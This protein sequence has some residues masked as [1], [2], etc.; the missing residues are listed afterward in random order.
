MSIVL[1]LRSIT[2]RYG[3]IAAL[4]DIDLDVHGGTFV[5]LLGPSG[6]GKTTLLR[7]V[8]GI[9]IPD[10]GDV[11]LGQRRVTTDP[12]FARNL[13][14]VFQDYALFPHMSV[15]ENVAFGIRMRGNPQE[16]KRPDERV[17]E[18]LELVGLS[19]FATR[20]PAELSGGQ[21]QRVA[22][23]RALAPRPSLLLMDEPLSNLDAKVREEM[24]SELK[25]IQRKADVTTL[26]V[27][28]DQEEA[29]AL[30]DKVVVMTEGRIAQIG[31]P[32]EVYSAPRDRFVADFIGKANILEGGGNPG[33]RQFETHTGV[34]LQLAEGLPEATV[35]V[36]IRPEH[37]MLSPGLKPNNSFEAKILSITYVGAARY[38]TLD[39]CGTPILSLLVNSIGMHRVSVGQL[40]RIAIS[41]EAIRPLISEA[42]V[43][44][45]Q[46]LAESTDMS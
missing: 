9:Q 39:L 15:F 24:R 13:A 44:S 41:P 2:K 37:V 17:G 5:S 30:S 28:H 29:L 35:A 27:T 10:S 18:V 42:P 4:V 16:R 14:M 23:A 25:D 46:K 20:Y 11:V 19:G 12:P 26:Y 1:S 31:T 32:E 40:V 21:Q 8:A 3:E 36:V 43:T 22:I 7:I 45:F 38:L 33:A 34:A 6:C